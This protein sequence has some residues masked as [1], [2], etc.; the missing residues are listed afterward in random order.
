MHCVRVIHEKHDKTKLWY[1]TDDILLYLPQEAETKQ[2]QIDTP[3][4]KRNVSCVS[5]EA[6]TET[7]FWTVK[8]SKNHFIL[9]GK[10]LSV[11][12][13]LVQRFCEFL[14][15]K[16]VKYQRDIKKNNISVDILT[17]DAAI[18]ARKHITQLDTM[19]LQ[20]S[21]F[22]KHVYV[23]C[24]TSDIKSTANITIVRYRASGAFLKS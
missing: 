2:F 3:L 6:L 19:L 13:F 24:C 8:P 10:M 14:D 23:L 18:V 12:E 20:L 4:G 16:K 5:A 11:K 7:G 1:V 9:D 17:E 21:A 22:E 15:S